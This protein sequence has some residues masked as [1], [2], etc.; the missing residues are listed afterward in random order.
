[1]NE[2]LVKVKAELNLVELMLSKSRRNLGATLARL[3]KKINH[4]AYEM[5]QIKTGSL[6]LSSLLFFIQK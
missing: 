2:C 4:L 5:S 6:E 3:K 1:V